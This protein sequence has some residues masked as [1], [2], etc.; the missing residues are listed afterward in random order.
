MWHLSIYCVYEKRQCWCLSTK[1]ENSLALPCLS[2]LWS[3]LMIYVANRQKRTKPKQVSLN[4]SGSEIAPSWSPMRLKIEYW[5]PEFH[6]WS[7]VGDLLLSSE[8]FANK[9]LTF[10]P[11]D[12]FEIKMKRVFP[13]TTCTT[14]QA[15][16]FFFFFLWFLIKY[17]LRAKK[18]WLSKEIQGTGARNVT[19]WQ[20][21]GLCATERDLCYRGWNFQQTKGQMDFYY[22]RGRIHFLSKMSALES[23]K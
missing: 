17:A 4:F 8:P 12:V 16:G 15:G 9:C 20:H 2:V 7:P 14:S 19:R 21:G 6:K 22:I 18:Q 1:Y 3:C 13:L 5:R 11:A 23:E 10:H